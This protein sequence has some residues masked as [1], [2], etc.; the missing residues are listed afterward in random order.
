M[1]G[2]GEQRQPFWLD[3]DRLE[4]VTVTVSQPQRPQYLQVRAGLGRLGQRV[5]PASNR[6]R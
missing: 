3:E 2:V 4:R 6:F 1:S 5:A